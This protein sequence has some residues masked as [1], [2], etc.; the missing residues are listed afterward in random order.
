MSADSEPFLYLAQLAE[1]S[2]LL[3]ELCHCIGQIAHVVSPFRL[4]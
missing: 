1:A 3:F 2:S 4:P